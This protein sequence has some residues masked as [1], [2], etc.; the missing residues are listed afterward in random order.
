MAVSAETLTVQSTAFSHEGNIPSKY[1]CEGKGINPPLE[2]LNIP[3]Q[4][5][6]LVLIM[7]DPD[8]PRQTFD[9]WLVW[10]IRPEKDAI[11]ENTSPGT[12]GKNSLGK[13]IYTPPCPP[14]GVHRYFFKVFAID[15]MLDLN[16]GADKS[17]LETAI[18]G[19]VLASGAL[20]GLYKKGMR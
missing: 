17:A 20:I 6:S 13:N 8:A 9:H 11:K 12:T 14:T 2:I 3:T 5:K 1:T 10:N 7:D 16:A 4:A 15:T 18:K 19:H